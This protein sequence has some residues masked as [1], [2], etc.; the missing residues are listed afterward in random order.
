MKY[1]RDLVIAGCLAVRFKRHWYL[2]RQYHAI[3]LTDEEFDELQMMID[4][5]THEH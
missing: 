2:G 5:V 1:F 3:L 4:K